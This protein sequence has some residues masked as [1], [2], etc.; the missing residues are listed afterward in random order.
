MIRNGR[1]GGA[2]SCSTIRSGTAS[3]ASAARPAATA[4]TSSPI[5]TSTT[6]NNPR[7]VYRT[8]TTSG[9]SDGHGNGQPAD[10]ALVGQGPPHPSHRHGQDRPPQ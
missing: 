5:A 1:R 2:A 4:P 3:R 10:H 7:L 8:S 6:H 9:A